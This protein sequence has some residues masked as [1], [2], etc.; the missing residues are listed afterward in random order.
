[1][2]GHYAA[3]KSISSCTRILKV[4]IKRLKQRILISHRVVVLAGYAKSPH[5]T[6]LG[7]EVCL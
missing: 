2:S 3:T 1:L 4:N 7:Y 5:P 6:S